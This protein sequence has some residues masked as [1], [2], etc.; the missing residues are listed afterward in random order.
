MAIF[1]PLCEKE[2]KLQRVEE[3]KYFL[4]LPAKMCANY[5]YCVTI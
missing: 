1:C 4:L 2:I 5:Y 3:E